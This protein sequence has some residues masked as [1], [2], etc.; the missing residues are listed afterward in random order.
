MLLGSASSA[1][2]VGAPAGSVGDGCRSK[3]LREPPELDC[4]QE[5]Q[6]GVGAAGPCQVTWLQAHLQAASRVLHRASAERTWRSGLSSE[7][8]AE[9]VW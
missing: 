8:A 3:V 4:A 9:H 7:R 2:S 1:S 5:C 6:Q